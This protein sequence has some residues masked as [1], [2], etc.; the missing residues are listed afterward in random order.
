[1]HELSFT[2]SL[3][4]KNLYLY[5]TKEIDKFFEEIKPSNTKHTQKYVFYKE[6]GRVP[7]TRELLKR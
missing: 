5:R 3:S 2:P 4:G 7:L 6:N 1:M